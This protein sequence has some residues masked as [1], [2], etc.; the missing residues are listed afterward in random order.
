[1]SLQI[2]AQT[3]AKNLDGKVEESICDLTLIGD[4]MSDSVIVGD[5]TNDPETDSEGK[6]KKKQAKPKT[7]DPVK[8]QNG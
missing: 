8:A 3:I 4:P 7:S 6:K 2:P 5:P 1:M